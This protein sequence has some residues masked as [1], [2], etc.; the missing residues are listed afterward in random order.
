MIRLPAAS[1]AWNQLKHFS[2]LQKLSQTFPLQT[3]TL[4]YET[5][6]CQ[7]F[8]NTFV[9]KAF[10]RSIFISLITKVKYVF[11]SGIVE[12]WENSEKYKDKNKNWE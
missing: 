5:I 8:H 1:Y 10:P 2:S 11:L 7:F 9:F 3:N 12:N 6:H 4:P